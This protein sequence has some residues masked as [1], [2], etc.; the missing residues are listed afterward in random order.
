MTDETNT[1]SGDAP[2]GSLPPPQDDP[3]WV[4][5]LAWAMS[6]LVIA[7]AAFHIGQA[8]AK[9]EPAPAADPCAGIITD[10]SDLEDSLRTAPESIRPRAIAHYVV[11]SCQTG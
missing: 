8:T 10:Y 5:N 6:T 9:P 4:R 7:I 11:G 1:P 3:A 2:L